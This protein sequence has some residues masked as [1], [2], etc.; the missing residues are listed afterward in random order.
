METEFVGE[1]KKTIQF[2]TIATFF[3][4]MV[5]TLVTLLYIDFSL[6][7]MGKKNLDAKSIVERWGSSVV[8]LVCDD[9]FGNS[10]S[11]SGTLWNINNNF[12]VTTNKHVAD[13]QSCLIIVTPFKNGISDVKNSLIYRAKK[14][15]FRTLDGDFDYLSLS[16]EERETDTPLSKLITLAHKINE[17]CDNT[18]YSTGEKILILGYPAV[19][20]LE[21]T[22]LTVNEGIISGVEKGFSFDN[23][24]P[25]TWY[26]TSAKIEEGNSGGTAVASDGCFI[27]IPT[28]STIGALESQGRLLIYSGE[29]SL[30]K[31]S[32]WLN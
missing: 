4:G 31:S 19:G 18:L 32:L 24:A 27:G 1:E 2:V 23:N 17:R 3:I 8:R 5:L 7:I 28:W 22:A 20:T 12:I 16:L 29:A 21:G 14:D 26:V 13:S 9:G 6:G 11:G 10:W 15:S 30:I 25:F